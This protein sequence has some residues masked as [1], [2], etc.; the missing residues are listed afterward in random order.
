MRLGKSLLAA[1]GVF[2]LCS[3][4]VMAAV[5]DATI[6]ADAQQYR[7]LFSNAQEAGERPGGPEEGK[8]VDQAL[9]NIPL[10]QLTLEQ[11]SNLL[12]R[13]PVFQSPKTD[14]ALDAVLTKVSANN[15]LN[16]A[17]ASDLRLRLL[18][19]DSKPEERL[20][21][22]KVVLAH[23]AIAQAV[24]AGDAGDVFLFAGSF[25]PSALEQLRPDLL[26]LG[27]SVTSKS[28]A[29]LFAQGADFQLAIAQTLK[30]EDL[31]KFSPLREKLA[32]AAT[33]KLK[34]QLTDPE[35]KTVSRALRN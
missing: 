13:L 18:T 12:H 7:T 32:D 4:R 15:D 34:S 24:A 23:P 29:R 2:S 3:A 9:A 17:W 8:F 1:V 5:D 22:V 35:Q 27:D 28:P 31:K 10:D 16:G 21:A 25:T 20:A 30:P 14:P 33:E 6:D 11:I 19:S 26:K